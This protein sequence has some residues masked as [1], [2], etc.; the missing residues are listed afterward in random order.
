MRGSSVVGSALAFAL[1]FMHSSGVAQETEHSPAEVRLTARLERAFEA[2]SAA[3]VRRIFDHEFRRERSPLLLTAAERLLRTFSRA[4]DAEFVLQHLSV[5]RDVLEA[6][7]VARAQLLQGNL[8]DADELMARWA[9]RQDRLAAALLRELASV[10]VRRG[11]LI[12]AQQSLELARRILPQ[13]R[14][15]LLEL[16]SVHL[17]RGLPEPAVALLQS[18]LQLATHDDATRRRLAFALHAAGRADDAISELLRLG[19]PRDLCS[20][21]RIALEDGDVPRAVA[22]AR[23]GLNRSSEAEEASAQRALGLALARAGEQAAAIRALRRSLL[24][25]P[26]SVEARTRLGELDEA[27]ESGS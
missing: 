21:S 8:A 3:R 7:I 26:T 10:R 4:Q 20:A 5:P 27:F 22:L 13:D 9:G 14:S 16:A 24:L 1:V 17:A 23:R 6:R 18:R 11:E 12:Q 19:E 25:E 15:I 2:N